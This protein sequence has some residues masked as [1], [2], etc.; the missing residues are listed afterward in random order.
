MKRATEGERAS[1]PAKTESTTSEPGAAP[2]V[3]ET[4]S[5]PTGKKSETPDRGLVSVSQQMW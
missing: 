1:K 3:R 4:D 5:P 2:Q